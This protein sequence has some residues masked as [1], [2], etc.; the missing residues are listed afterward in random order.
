[1]AA[2]ARKAALLSSLG[3][4]LEYYDFIIY[5]M[6]AEQLSSLFF[7]S[8][9]A[10]VGLIKTFAIFAVGYFARPFGGV[11]FGLIGDTFGRKKAFLSIMLL[12]AAATFGI[13]LMPTYAHIGAAAPCLLLLLRLLQGISVGAEL[14][15]AITVVCEH[16]QE[17]KRGIYSSVV[18]AGTS[19]GALLASFVLFLL[20]GNADK[21]QIMSWGWRLPFLLGGALAVANYYIR[22]HLQETP[23]FTQ[24]KAE[25]TTQTSLKEPLICLLREHWPQLIQGVGLTLFIS[26]LVI[27]GLYLPTY[28]NLHYGYAPADIYL[29]IM[30]GMFWSAIALPICGLIADRF[31]KKRM[32]ITTMLVFLAWAFPLFAL[33]KMQTFTAVLGFM[34]AYQTVIALVTSC[35][36]PILASLFPTKTRFTGIAAS[37]NIAYSTMATLPVAVTAIIRYSENPNT[38]IWVLMAFALTSAVCASYKKQLVLKYT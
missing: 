6:M 9:V 37:Y 11:V 7:P 23:E 13:G 1:M 32:L 4:G 22:K 5:G 26:S 34:I 21:E 27:G 10:W 20:T 14:P 16:A 36:F 25:R 30:G 15:G 35:Y 8:D 12:M 3:A 2:N 24:M 28:L 31:D 33:L 38:F 19:L 29:A 17:Q 18:M